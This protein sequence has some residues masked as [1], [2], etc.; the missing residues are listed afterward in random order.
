MDIATIHQEAKAAAERAA[1][2]MLKRIGGD[3]M[4]CGFAWVN[5]H[6]VSLATRQG[7]EF[8]KLGFTKGYGKGAGI[9]LWNP[10]GSPVQNIDTKEAGAQAYAEVFKRH[11]FEAYAGS[12]LD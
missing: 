10:S 11:G 5:I 1:A 4:A 6:G 3:R 9:E 7:K 12:R 2:D 8:K